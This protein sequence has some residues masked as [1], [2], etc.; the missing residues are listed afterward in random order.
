MF[1]NKLLQKLE[2]GQLILND[3]SILK[4]KLILNIFN[5][6]KKST[7]EKIFN[8]INIDIIEYNIK[9]YLKIADD[10]FPQLIESI[11]QLYIKNHYLF[12]INK[13]ITETNYNDIQTIKINLKNKSIETVTFDYF[14]K[15]LNLEYICSP[16][17]NTIFKI[18]KHFELETFLVTD[19]SWNDGNIFQKESEIIDLRTLIPRYNSHCNFIEIKQLFKTWDN[20]SYKIIFKF[21][22]NTIK[23]HILNNPDIKSIKILKPLAYKIKIDYNTFKFNNPSQIIK[24]KDQS[25]IICDRLNHMIREIK[26]DKIT[27]LYGSGNSGFLNGKNRFSDFNWPSDITIDKFENIYVA[28]TLNNSIR[29]IN[30]YGLVTCIAGINTKRGFQ[31]GLGSKSIFKFPQGIVVDNYNNIYVSDVNNYIRIMQPYIIKII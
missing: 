1:I 20:Y 5:K 25:L 24:K 7:I 23:Y 14:I 8:Y 31:N 2:K 26:N 3:K 10:S 15:Y 12:V 29:K 22:D 30:K 19:N 18:N 6:V 17:I 9:V 16:L 28:D 11:R 13:N 21:E 27:T 4:F